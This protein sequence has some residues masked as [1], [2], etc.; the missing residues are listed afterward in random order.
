[1]PDVAVL[2][3]DETVRTGLRGLEGIF[4]DRAG[5]GIEAAELAGELAGV[6]NRAVAGG[7]RIVRP[8]ARRRHWPK[9]DRGLDWPGDGHWG[10]PGPLGEI[11]D[12]V[13]SERVDLLLGHRHVEIDHHAHHRL[14]ALGRVARAHAVDV[15]AAAAGIEE[16]LFAG[17][18]R[19]TR[20]RLLGA[21]RRRGVKQGR[22]R[23]QERLL[24][25]GSSSTKYRAQA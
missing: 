11:L 9:L 22:D 2:V 17:S 13:L 20:L 4:L 25:H 10:G 5:L 16:G 3:L 19:E 8:R 21:C 24:R 23:G 1:E 15:V 14:P 6:P 7:K 18:V 12:Q